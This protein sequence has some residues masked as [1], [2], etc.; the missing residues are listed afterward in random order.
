M[1]ITQGDK[2]WTQGEKRCIYFYKLN[3]ICFMYSAP[4]KYYPCENSHFGQKK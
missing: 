2:A 1:C 4:K 3:A